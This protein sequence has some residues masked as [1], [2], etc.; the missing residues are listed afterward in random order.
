ME[1][2]A[3]ALG[4]YIALLYLRFMAVP[5]AMSKRLAMN[6]V[7]HEVGRLLT[8]ANGYEAL[9]AAVAFLNRLY[10]HEFSYGEGKFRGE[11]IWRLEVVEV[12]YYGVFKRA[13]YE[14]FRGNRRY[15]E[16]LSDEDRE[17]LRRLLRSVK[18]NFRDVKVSGSILLDGL[19]VDD[20]CR[21]MKGWKHL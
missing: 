5:S 18:F 8:G 12:R 4:A 17:D 9:E 6:V 16:S 10:L 1:T 2:S 11:A 20:A 19:T 13:C 3:K 15:V 14:P 7:R 21:Y